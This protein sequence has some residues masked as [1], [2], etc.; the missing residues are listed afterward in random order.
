MCFKNSTPTYTSHPTPYQN[1]QKH[2]TRALLYASKI[3]QH[4]YTLHILHLQKPRP[5]KTQHLGFKIYIKKNQHQYTFD[6]LHLQKN[7]NPQKY[8]TWLSKYA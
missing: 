5:T 3:N 8:A 1:Q 4:Q 7:P 2:S 6:F